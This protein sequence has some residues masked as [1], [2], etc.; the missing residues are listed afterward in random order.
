MKLGD[1]KEIVIPEKIRKEL[2][3]KEVIIC[4]KK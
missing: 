3:K 4:K 1:S 2:S